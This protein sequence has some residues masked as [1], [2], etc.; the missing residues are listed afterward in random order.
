LLLDSSC[1]GHFLPLL[2]LPFIATSYQTY[3][4][5]LLPCHAML[6]L[7]VFSLP[8]CSLCL[9]NAGIAGSRSIWVSF[10]HVHLVH[11]F[12]PILGTAATYRPIPGLDS[13]Q[14]AASCCDD[15]QADL[16]PLTRRLGKAS[17]LLSLFPSLLALFT[18]SH[19][20][21]SANRNRPRRQI[22]IFVRFAYQPQG[23]RSGGDQVPRR[24]GRHQFQPGGL[25]R[26]HEAGKSGMAGRAGI[27]KQIPYSTNKFPV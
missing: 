26:R 2:L 21:F 23:V 9:C 15:L 17:L 6:S 24:G 22:L 7:T 4:Y 19:V 3:S 16:T 11:Q 10:I 25:R 18:D 1:F 12:M 14:I 8:P 5:E 13:S 27:Y 20:Q